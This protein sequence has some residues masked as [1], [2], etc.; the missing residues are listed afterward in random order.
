M[1]SKKHVFRN[2]L[3]IMLVIML[4]GCSPVQHTAEVYETLPT[5][6]PLTSTSIPA[7]ALTQT[8]MPQSIP[9]IPSSEE[10]HINPIEGLNPEFIMGADV[11][12]L[13]QLEENGGKFY[14]QGI[15][16]DALEILKNHGVNWIRLRIWNDPTDLA[17]NPLGG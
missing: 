1:S 3:V 4:V 16:G 9:T 10:F 17:G 14:D 13:S 12:M 2:S 5:S 8:T 6:L 15:E 11:S 7:P